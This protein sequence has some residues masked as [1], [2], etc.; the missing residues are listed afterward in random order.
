MAVTLAAMGHLVKPG[1]KSLKLSFHGFCPLL[2]GWRLRI[3]GRTPRAAGWQVS[4]G[5]G[6]GIVMALDLPSAF[7]QFMVGH[8]R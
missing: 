8:A 2:G 1:P 5:K 6:F 4:R 3:Q 7:H